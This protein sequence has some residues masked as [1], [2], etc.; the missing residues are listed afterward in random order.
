MR[1]ESELR[2]ELAQLLD[3]PTERNRSKI[4][5]LVWVSQQRWTWPMAQE[6]AAKLLQA[7]RRQRGLACLQALADNLVSDDPV[8]TE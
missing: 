8:I 7:A 1:G 3:A 2:A 5:S 4:V 6:V